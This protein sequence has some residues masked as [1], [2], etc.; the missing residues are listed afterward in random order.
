MSIPFAA[1]LDSFLVTQQEKG[2]VKKE[3]PSH[4][5]GII[6]PLEESIN[7]QLKANLTHQKTLVTKRNFLTDRHFFFIRQF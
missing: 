1:L 7:F 5:M 6:F 2:K 3:D 4:L